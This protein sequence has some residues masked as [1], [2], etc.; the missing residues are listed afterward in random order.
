MK[1]V[2]KRFAY[3]L[4]TAGIAAAAWHGYHYVNRKATPTLE[5]KGRPAIPVRTATVGTGSLTHAIKLTGA[6][7]ATRTVDVVPKI[8]GRLESLALEDGT[9]V[10]EG[11]KVTNRQILAVIDHRDIA[12]QLAQ[13]RAAVDT[14][15]A[16]IA[17]AQVVLKDRLREKNRMGKLF[18]DGSTTEQQRDL[19]E[20]AHEQAVTEL[21]QAEAKL[22]QAEAAVEL[23]D[24]NLTEAFLRAPMDGVVSAKYVDPGAMVNNS[25][26]IVQIIPMEELKFLVAVPGPYLRHLAAG[27]TTVTVL[28]DAAPDRNFSGVIARIHPMVDPVTRTATV[29][30]RLANETDAAGEW[31]LRPGLYA[32]GRIV[33]DVRR[34]VT[35]LPADVL[36]RRGERFLAFVV[37]DGK[38]E[39]RT[40]KLGVRDGN[41]LEIVEGLKA[42]EQV[43]VAGQHRLTDGQPV[44]FAD[45]PARREP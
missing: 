11:T 7:E 4:A 23:T 21:A 45:E 40:L 42:G 9:P 14:A 20:T 8:A 37:T 6:L 29:E 41:R 12:A 43:V 39:T 35:V 22:V 1:A 36:L 19:A 17:T 38:A 10:L 25:T 44:R 26:R 30:V 2:L 3:L 13:A 16:A 33:L 32:E 34:D 18:A 5:D 15:R 27:R 24:V 28:S 31:V